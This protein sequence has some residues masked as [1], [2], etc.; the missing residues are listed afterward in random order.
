MVMTDG[1]LVV[2]VAVAIIKHTILLVAKAVVVQVA[3]NHLTQLQVQP[4]L[5]AVAVEHTV[6]MVTELPV[7]EKLV[8]LAQS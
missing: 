6:V 8:A 7:Q 2:A 1:L 3:K 5:V 4:I